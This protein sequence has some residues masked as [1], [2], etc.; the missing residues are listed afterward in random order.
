MGR[1]EYDEGLPFC[2]SLLSFLES[3]LFQVVL[4]R[5][6]LQHVLSECFFW[7]RQIDGIPV[8][9]EA[10]DPRRPVDLDQMALR[11]IEVEGE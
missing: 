4:P 6:R 8:A 2:L 9:R 1:F 7:E 5:C 11:V 10:V 3:F